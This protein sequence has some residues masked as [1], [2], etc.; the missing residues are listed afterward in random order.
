MNTTSGNK[1]LLYLAVAL[2]VAW[3]AN[4]ASAG[5]PSSE[6][7]KL[8]H[9]AQHRDMM[10]VG[11]DNLQ[12][13][14]AYQPTVHKQGNRY[15]LYVGQHSLGTNP[16]T[17]EPLPSFNPLTGM[18]EPNGTSLVDVTNPRNPVY[19]AHIP[20]GTPVAP[21]ATPTAGGAQ[22]VR[23]CDGSTLPIRNDK[24]Y[25]LR[26]YTGAADNTSAHEIWDTTDPSHPKPVRT[27]AGGNPVIG[28]LA[29]THKNWWECDTGIAYLVG[30]RAT[31]TAAGWRAG[32]RI[33][34]FD[35]SDPANP[36]FLR[37]WALDGQQ[38]G[39]VIPPHFTTVPAIHGPI[40][41]GPDTVTNPIAGT[42]AT[43]DRV[44]FAYGVGSNG[45]MQI[46]KR[47]A[48]LPPPYGTGTA[49]DFKT[50][51]RGRLIMN[52][53]NG[54]HTS[55]PIGTITVPDFVTDTGNDTGF[56]TRDIVVITSE[57][58]GAFCNQFRHLTFMTD[59]TTEGRP[60][61]I[62]TFQVPAS[63]GAFCE[64]GG[65]FGPHATNEE[66]GPP[67]YQKIVFVS[68]FNAGVR[69]IDVRDPYN[70][71]EVAFFIPE[72]TAFTDLRCGTLNGIPNTCKTV[73]QT[74]N[75]ATDDRGFVYIVD[76]ADTGLH[77]LALSGDARKIIEP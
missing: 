12:H 64:R 74:N 16:V 18:N 77:V 54:A 48:L 6:G 45:V 65:R 41:T 62:A 67:F 71:H 34:I 47:S 56:T 40:S 8:A 28:N 25:M 32:N 35:L 55:W 36:G 7:Q 57:A 2:V 27:V 70:P 33:M 58:G 68:Y 37:D 10:L 29:D 46:V 50:P 76:R 69:A 22:M 59:V 53:N 20:V 52:P 14:S 44:Y 23:V 72:T 1:R 63:N 43:L 75:V 5:T 49:A 21:P 38:P 4:H 73:I 19:L 24:V 51:E 17:G 42:G 61:S 15:I 39:G 3:G 66:F 11:T 30:R 60:Q 13:R 31:D 26:T 9:A